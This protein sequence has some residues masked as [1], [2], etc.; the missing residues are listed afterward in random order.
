VDGG[1][2]DSTRA[3]VRE[4]AN[5]YSNVKL[6]DNPKK[7]VPAAMNVGIHHSSHDI[8]L[9]LGAHAEY[10]PGYVSNSI[11][12]LLEENCASVGGVI[13]PIA[14]SPVGKA[15]AIATT[16][17]FGIGNA[18]YRYAKQRQKVDTVFGG[19]WQKKNISS[20][21]GFNEAWVRNQDYE[22]NCR[23]REQI[24]DII[25]DPS[26]Q[27]RYYCRES[28]SA[29]AKQYYQYGFWR[30]KTF[31]KHPQSFTLRQAAPL[32]LLCGLLISV[33]ILPI[34]NKLG[35]LLP[36]IYVL[37]TFLVSL[38][39]SVKHKR[40]RYLV[41]LPI[42]FATLHLSWAFGFAKSLLNKLFKL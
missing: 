28:I 25:L 36:T 35:L 4:V 41:L 31:T 32:L 12:I 19:C 33:L 2:S 24:G 18:K 7:H 14:N 11:R 26:I 16:N 22:L 8:L 3:D 40:P 1:S 15:I 21:G 10:D 23:L 20:I 38:W 39:L 29:L 9:W 17:K 5:I 27:C 42:I 34:S 30:F 13:T 6:I 37:C